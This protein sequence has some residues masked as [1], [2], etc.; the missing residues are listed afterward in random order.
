MR[1][2]NIFETVPF[3]T[4]RLIW[5]ITN[6]ITIHNFLW[7]CNHHMIYLYTMHQKLY[8]GLCSGC[9]TMYLSIGIS[10]APTGRLCICHHWRVRSSAKEG[11]HSQDSYCAILGRVNVK[12]TCQYDG[13]W[14]W[15]LTNH[16]VQL[17]TWNIVIGPFRSWLALYRQ[18]DC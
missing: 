3:F 15:E 17:M 5:H 1:Q 4:W 8:R 6:L 10:H 9:P 12:F 13:D 7:L 16:S 2:L 11:W 18:A 14:L